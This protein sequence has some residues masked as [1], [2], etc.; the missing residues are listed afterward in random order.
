[1]QNR[2]KLLDLVA[3]NQFATERGTFD[4]QAYLKAF[5]EEEKSFNDNLD[6]NRSSTIVQGGRTTY[7]DLATNKRLRDDFIRQQVLIG[8]ESQGRRLPEVETQISAIRNTPQVRNIDTTL[9][10]QGKQKLTDREV[11]RL[12][13][14]LSSDDEDRLFMDKNSAET[15]EQILRDKLGVVRGVNTSSRRPTG[16]TGTLPTVSSSRDRKSFSLRKYLF[17]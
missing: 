9:V 10:D 16:G 17:D 13:L 12:S 3:A 7:G 1:M 11:L 2:D 6:A 5:R 4:R 15:Y 8:G 14:L